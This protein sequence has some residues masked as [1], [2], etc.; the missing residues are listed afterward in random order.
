MHRLRLK[1]IQFDFSSA[2]ITSGSECE[3][4]KICI[5]MR[6]FYY[7]QCIWICCI[8]M[9]LSTVLIFCF[10]IGSHRWYNMNLGTWHDS[11]TSF[12][13]LV[14]LFHYCYS[15]I[16]M[17]CKKKTKK[18]KIQSNPWF[19]TEMFCR[20]ACWCVHIFHIS[21]TDSIYKMLMSDIT[22]NRKLQLMSVSV[23][24]IV[25]FADFVLKLI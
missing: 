24:F 16:S 2:K 23:C 7:S 21:N 19:L 12:I 18:K 25:I 6:F 4:I 17:Q 10:L 1:R 8:K 15:R 11:S 20:I 5:E 9:E 22:K 14:T 13:Q 3:H